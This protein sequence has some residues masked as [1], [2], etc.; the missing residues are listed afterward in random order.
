[1]HTLHIH[2][3]TKTHPHYTRIST[4]TH[5]ST[6]HVCTDTH[7]T[8]QYTHCIH[9]SIQYT[10]CTNTSKCTHAHAHTNIL[11]YSQTHT[12]THTKT[13]TTHTHSQ[14]YTYVEHTYRTQ[15]YGTHHVEINL[16]T[17]ESGPKKDTCRRYTDK[18]THTHRDTH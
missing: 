1:M 18:H 12:H 13:Y 2:R 5:I 8:I 3:Q 7:T 11:T 17:Q 14:A 9:T 10:H 6:L 15:T 4:H 16:G